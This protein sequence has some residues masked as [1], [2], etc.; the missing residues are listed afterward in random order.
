M[1][2]Y[3][4]DHVY[5]WAID[6][7][8]M[9]LSQITALFDRLVVNDLGVNGTADTVRHAGSRL[10]YHVSGRLYNYGTAMALGVVVVVILLWARPY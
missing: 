7:I 9:R 5:Q 6:N 3:Y 1:N 4:L 2:G 8:A 10:R